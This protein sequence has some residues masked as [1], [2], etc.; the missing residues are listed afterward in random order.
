MTLTHLKENLSDDIVLQTYGIITQSFFVIRRNIS[1]IS[2]KGLMLDNDISHIDKIL[3]TFAKKLPSNYNG[4]LYCCEEK[5]YDSR[6]K[7]FLEL[8]QVKSLINP[9]IIGQQYPFGSKLYVSNSKELIILTNYEDHFLIIYEYKSHSILNTIQKLEQILKLFEKSVQEYAV[10]I[11]FRNNLGFL[12]L[13]PNF[14]GLGI[15]LSYTVKLR[16]KGP[17]E[18]QFE[19]NPE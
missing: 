5:D 4:T 18:M 15:S 17:N 9:Q 14:S 13:N 10:N 19:L 8:Y 12:T 7:T 3:E 11:S 1:G 16:E 2:F 6:I